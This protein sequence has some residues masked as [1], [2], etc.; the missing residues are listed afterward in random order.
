MAFHVHEIIS[1]HIHCRNPSLLFIIVSL[2]VPVVT[3]NVALLVIDVQNCFLPTGTLPV[4]EGDLVIPIINEIRQNYDNIFSLV[5]FSQDWHCD[6]HVSFASQHNGKNPYDTTVLHYNSTG[7]KFP[8]A[9]NK[10]SIVYDS[11]DHL[12]PSTNKL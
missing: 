10:I 5:V 7:E 6:D 2:P 3:D 9:V 1:I 8:K 11:I 4:T 12:F